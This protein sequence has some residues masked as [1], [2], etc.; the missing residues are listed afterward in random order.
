MNIKPA[1]A[2]CPTQSCQLIG[3]DLFRYLIDIFAEVHTGRTDYGTLCPKAWAAR[4]TVQ[5]A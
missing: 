3:L 5:S 4:A 2:E 1:R